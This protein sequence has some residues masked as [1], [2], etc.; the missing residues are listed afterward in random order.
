MRWY[1]WYDGKIALWI[2]SVYVYHEIVITFVVSF[3]IYFIVLSDAN[4]YLIKSCRVKQQPNH[5]YHH[6]HIIHS[7]EYEFYFHFTFFTPHLLSWSPENH[8]G[9]WIG[10][11]NV[12]FKKNDENEVDIVE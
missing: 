11:L 10:C 6:Q 5:F 8:S 4:P 2:Y 7:C 9:G 3:E 1:L 12:I